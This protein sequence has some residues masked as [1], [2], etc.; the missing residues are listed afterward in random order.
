MVGELT[1]DQDGLA[2]KGKED[3]M[4]QKCKVTEL[5]KV[6]IKESK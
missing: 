5:S 1:G 2:M 4:I 3:E 6:F